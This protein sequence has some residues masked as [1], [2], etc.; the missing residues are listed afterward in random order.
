MES[1][2][3]HFWDM[4]VDELKREAQSNS[5]YKPRLKRVKKLRKKFKKRINESDPFN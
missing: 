1:E 2:T 4:R 3:L 5:A